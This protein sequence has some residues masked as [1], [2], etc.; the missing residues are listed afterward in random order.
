MNDTNQTWHTEQD[1]QEAGTRYDQGKS[2]IDLIPGCALTEVAKVYDFSHHKTPLYGSIPPTAFK[3]LA[4]VYTFGCIKYDDNNWRKG[5]SWSRCFGPMM[6]HLNKFWINEEKN[7]EDSNLHHLAHAAWNAI[8]LI[9]YDFLNI[10]NDDRVYNNNEEFSMLPIFDNINPTNYPNSNM[11]NGCEYSYC[12]NQALTYAWSFWMNYDQ[13]T[14]LHN[15]AFVTF[16]CF[17]LMDFERLNI[18]IDDRPKLPNNSQSNEDQFAPV[19]LVKGVI[20]NEGS[21][22]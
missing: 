17:L 18:G 4:D 21:N 5:M 16:Y 20:L 7:D 13:S 19:E 2:R 15:L 8:A 3:D 12:Y 1:K 22:F 9:E 11:L 6:R 14:S 10:G